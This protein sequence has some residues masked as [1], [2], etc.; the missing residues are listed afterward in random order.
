MKKVN[1]I[2]LG[3]MAIVLNSPL[4]PMA[5]ASDAGAFIG[6]M[7]TSKVLSNMSERTEAEKVQAYNSSRPA[8]AAP[9]SASAASSPQQ[10]LDQLD[11]LAANG[12]ITKEE[13]QARRKAILDSM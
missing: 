10:K 12:Y 4:A 11:K 8:Q 2:Y 1:A 3:V 9:S 5:Q 13:Y 6:G 7:L